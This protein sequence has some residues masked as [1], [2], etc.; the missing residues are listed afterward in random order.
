MKQVNIFTV[1][2]ALLGMSAISFTVVEKQAKAGEMTIVTQKKNIS[3]SLQGSGA[4]TID[5][6]DGTRKEKVKLSP[7]D[8]STH[9]F[10]YTG[11]VEKRT[12]TITGD[13]VT[14]LNCSYNQL[15]NLNVHKN[16]ALI[17]LN[18]GDNQLTSLDV[19]KNLALK[20]LRCRNNQLKSLD[21]SAN[22]TLNNLRIQSNQFDTNDLNALFRS[23]PKGKGKKTV[24]ILG[25]P[26]INTCNR[27]LAEKKGWT[28]DDE[29]GF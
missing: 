26:G 10:K 9:T 7:D 6:G 4:A 29:R 24:A 15:T 18:C 21:V 16:E 1:I 11:K 17:N 25:N 23:L 2:L 14:A 13:D 20:V 19:S 22:V 8:F 12:I 5:W 27:S 28:I 3:I